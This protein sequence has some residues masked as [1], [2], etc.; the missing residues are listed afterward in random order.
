VC[1]GNTLVTGFAPT[2]HGAA[3]GTLPLCA[4]DAEGSSVVTLQAPAVQFI[5]SCTTAGGRLQRNGG[6]TITATNEG[7]QAI[8]VPPV[9]ALDVQRRGLSPRF[10]QVVH[11]A[12]GCTTTR[13]CLDGSGGV[14]LVA[15]V[16]HATCCHAASGL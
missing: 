14:P 9:H 5:T 11:S 7:H 1:C 16:L 15:K 12:C 10:T 8:I 2:V 4:L 3:C 6:I 13:Q